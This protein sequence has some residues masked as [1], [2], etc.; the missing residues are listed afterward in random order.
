[1]G[2][3]AENWRPGA[4]GGSLSRHGLFISHPKGASVSWLLEQSEVDPGGKDVI[5]DQS[6]SR[7]SLC[8]SDVL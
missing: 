8:I 6:A 5:I 3:N 1:M 2:W 7:A 4:E